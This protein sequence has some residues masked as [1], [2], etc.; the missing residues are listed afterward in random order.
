MSELG[1]NI[2]LRE[3]VIGKGWDCSH[4]DCILKMLSSFYGCKVNLD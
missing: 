1:K 3:L 4:L 2:E